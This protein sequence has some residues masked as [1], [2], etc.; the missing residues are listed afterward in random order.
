MKM[1]LV[2]KDVRG[3]MKKPVALGSM[4]EV[5]KARVANEA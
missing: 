4:T 3:L 2:L 1:L 5:F